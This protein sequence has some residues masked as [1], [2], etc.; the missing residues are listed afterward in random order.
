MRMQA[1]LEDEVHGMEDMVEA[2]IAEVGHCLLACTCKAP[3]PKAQLL[4]CRVQQHLP[5]PLLGTHAG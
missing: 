3:C 5:C 1:M 4:G 2:K